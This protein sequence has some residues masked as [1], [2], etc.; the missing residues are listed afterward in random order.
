MNSSKRVLFLVEVAILSAFAYVLDI[1]P[2]LSIKFWAQGGS[3]SLAMIPVFIVAYRWGL[4][5]GLLSGVLF[6]LYQVAF[7]Q[8][9]ILTPIQG[10]LDYGV[11]FTV[12]GF[13]GLFAGRVQQ[14]L[15]ERNK[16]QFIWNVSAGILLGCT[17]RFFAHYFAG[18][19]FFESAVDG[20]G[21]YLYSF[22]YNI[23][24]LLPCFILNAIVIGF[25]F[26]K[27]PRLLVLK[28]AAIN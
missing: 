26:Y 5:G 20:M 11:A 15:K 25:L 22:L 14:S 18:V 2:F 10:I 17:L 21:I 1:I 28:T 6:G 3:V 7:G 24:Y 9:Y 23:S 13:A 4:K 8:A 12:L 16:I 19:A 27:Q